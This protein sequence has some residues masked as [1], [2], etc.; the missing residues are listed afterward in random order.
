MEVGGK[1]KSAAQVK[2]VAEYLIVAN[3][4]EICFGKK[5]HFGFLY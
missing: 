1:G 4:I 2:E 5:V 3:E